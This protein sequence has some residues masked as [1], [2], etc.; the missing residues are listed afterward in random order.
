M[1]L[2]ISAVNLNLQNSSNLGSYL[3]S[4]TVGTAK[5][6]YPIYLTLKDISEVLK[7]EYWTPASLAEEGVSYESLGIAQKRRNLMRAL[8]DY[9]DYEN[10]SELTGILWQSEVENEISPVYFH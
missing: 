6:P 7:P 8:A 4:I 10:V 2:D 1:E 5:V 9:A 3:T